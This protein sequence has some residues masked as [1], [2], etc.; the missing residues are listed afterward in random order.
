VWL[1]L[2]L[3]AVGYVFGVLRRRD[4]WTLELARVNT[5]MGL[6]VLAILLLANSPVLDFRKLSIASQLARV[7][8]GEIEL[9]EFDFLYARSHLARPGYLA[10]EELKAQVGDNDPEVAA[11]IEDPT[12]AMYRQPADVWWERVIYRPAA[13]E[14]PEGLRKQLTRDH[15]LAATIIPVLIRADLDESGEYEYVFAQLYGRG[16]GSESYFYSVAQVYFRQGGGWT[17]MAAM[18]AD[19]RTEFTLDGVTDGEISLE[20][21]RYKDLHIGDVVLRMGPLR[22]RPAE[23]ADPLSGIDGSQ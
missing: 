6:V 11:L 22:R 4:Q 1:I 3:F 9:R 21:S 5:G 14:V 12:E 15:Q 18:I 10:L 16:D 2:T 17:S 8:A 20:Q 7:E 13:F 23:V 19:L